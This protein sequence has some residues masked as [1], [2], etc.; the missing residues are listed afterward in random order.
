MDKVILTFL[1]SV[2]FILVSH[3]NIIRSCTE[4]PITNK[5]PFGSS[6]ACETL[7]LGWCCLNSPI[8]DRHVLNFW[9]IPLRMTGIVF[10]R[11]GG[12]G[13]TGVSGGCSEDLVLCRVGSVGELLALRF[14]R[15][16]VTS[17]NSSSWLTD[18]VFRKKK[19]KQNMEG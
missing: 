11:V 18:G 1:P 5:S 16:R 9:S 17:V 8:T 14:L 15:L 10:L 4:S 19:I 7:R 12:F 3:Y 6:L 13:R 2:A